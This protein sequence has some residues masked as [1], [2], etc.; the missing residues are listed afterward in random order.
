MLSEN[1]SGKE[2]NMMAP[3][4]SRV[5]TQIDGVMVIGEAVWRVAPERAEFLIE[6]MTG[7]PTAAQALNDNQLKSA[8]VA[9]AVAPLGVQ[10]A[11]LQTISLNVY[12]LYRPV[13]AL[14]GYGS[15]P[16]IGSGGFPAYGAGA[17][18]VPAEIQSAVYHARN[19]IRLNVRDPRRLGEIVDAVA[20]TGAV[21]AG[22]LSVTLSP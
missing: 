14:P 5:Q 19:I 9:Q 15:L 6:V 13:R 1:K 12:N 17:A 11:D 22:S 4:G 20:R 3:Y 18:S 7:A 16:M 8:Q 10:Q 2:S 21:I